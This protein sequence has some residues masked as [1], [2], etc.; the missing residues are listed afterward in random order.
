MSFY[1]S[2]MNDGMCSRIITC[3]CPM[4]NGIQQKTL[5]FQFFDLV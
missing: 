2:E 5:D 1:D 3:G 4:T